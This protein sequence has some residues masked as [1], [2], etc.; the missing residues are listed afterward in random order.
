LAPFGKL[1]KFTTKY[2]KYANIILGGLVARGVLAEHDYTYNLISDILSGKKD[3]LTSDDI[4]HLTQLGRAATGAAA[5][6]R[7]VMA[8]RKYGKLEGENMHKITTKEGNE[9][10]VSKEDA[11]K[12]NKAGNSKGQKAADADFKAAKKYDANGKEVKINETDGLKETSFK[13]KPGFIA[14]QAARR[15]PFTEKR[16]LGTNVSEGTVK[17][18]T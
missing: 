9:V 6:G 14:R 11:A 15:V 5:V 13:E 4:K 16:P 10:Y 1:A 3:S 17:V 18:Q 12:I 2:R 7:N 8:A